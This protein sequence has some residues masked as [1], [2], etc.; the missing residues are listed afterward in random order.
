[1]IYNTSARFLG[2]A[3]SNE[4]VYS[5]EEQE[6]LRRLTVTARF[7]V[8]GHLITPDCTPA[9]YVMKLPIE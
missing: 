3:K 9:D 8:Q 2:T 5:Q 7:D 1:M 4:K 6:I